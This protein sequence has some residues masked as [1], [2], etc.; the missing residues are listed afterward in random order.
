MEMMYQNRIL[1]IIVSVKGITSLGFSGR[2]K[3]R[4]QI[5][6]KGGRNGEVLG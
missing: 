5:R 3:C 2:H 6:I 4:E 1:N